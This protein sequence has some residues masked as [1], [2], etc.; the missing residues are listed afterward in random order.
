M[1]TSNDIRATFLGYFAKNGHT[2]VESSPLV[3]RND[4]TLMFANSGMVQFK[5]V[6][7]GQERRPY[8]TA[9]TAQK[10]VRAGG[11]HNDLDNV[12]YTARHHTFF[13][14][15]GNFSFGDYFKEQ[16]ITHAWTL[17]TRDF[18]LPR[19][20]LLVTVF[21]EDEEAAA[22]WR[23]VAGLPDQRIIRIATS[24][25][26]WR[27]G[28][29]G[30]CGPCSEIFF[31]HGEH[32]PGGPPGSPDEDGDRFI[33]IWNLVFMQFLEEPA[34]TRN[35]LPRPSIDTGMGLERF[36]AIL[37]GKHDN[38]DT[39]TF[40]AIILESA[41]LTGQEPDGPFRASHRVVADHLRAG[42]FLIADG[43]LP[44][45]E[46][47]GYVLRRILRRAMRHAH[48]MGA[49][50]PLLHR[51]FPTLE[52]QMA[53]AYP[54]LSRAAAL[55]TETLKLEEN[56]FRSL[57]ERGLGLL[58]GEKEKLAEGEALPGEVA[59]RL[60][61]TYGFPLDLTQD[62][63]RAEGR[64]V[65]VAGFEAAMAAQKQRARAAWAGTGEAAT[66]TLW[67]DLKE[68]LGATEFLGY[69]TERAEGTI[70]ALVAGKDAIGSAAQGREVAVVLNQTPFYGESGGQQGDAGV[71][72]A[73]DAVIRVRDTQKKLG[74][75]F[76]HLGT[77][78]RGDVEVGMAVVAEVDHA[79]R[80]AIRAHHSATHLLHEALRRRLGTHVAQ[81]GSLV[82]PDRLR[83]DVSQPTPIPAADLAVVEAEVNARIRENA[84]VTTRLMTPDAAVAEGAMALFGEKYGEEVRVVAMGRDEAAAERG[85]HYS[86]ELCGGTHVRRTGDIGLF[87][88][89]GEG[90]VSA[91]VRRVEA[92]TGAAA[93]AVV[94]EEA[95]LLREAAAALKA[96]PAD[97][98]A[99]VQAL[100]EDRRRLERELAETR[101]KLA[102]GG[103][104]AELEVVGGLRVALREL[105]EVPARDLKGLAEA[106][107]KSGADV[108]VLVSTEGG[109]A[110]IVAGVGEAGKGRADA[111]ALV[112]AAAA[113]V[114]GK[115]GGGRPDM[116]QAGGPEADKAAEA[117]AAAKAALAG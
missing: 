14:M 77:V 62:A 109:K 56:R 4:P 37:Q 1:S 20:K 104:G 103:A 65:D 6:F 112:R 110:S 64:A 93:L 21:N 45:N 39:D 12:G 71:I 7:T 98:P 54:E 24:D 76:I 50:D 19:E 91:G 28:D 66:E 9:T 111:V 11:K 44:S 113:A 58:E 70:T 88:I 36:A 49:R 73:G 102:T 99:R 86:I 61:D 53:A 92:V 17:L 41:S 78:E 79:R 8:S 107:L 34:G 95:R 30:P 94:E 47:R 13:E 15:L 16:A 55:I 83:F 35:P 67:F 97:I 27:M 18:A 81:K 68:K 117:L 38:Y 114:G 43:V 26:F 80:S 116:A 25:N 63:L 59:F 51:L 75:L 5:N 106:I 72:R 40:R 52:R 87:R 42:S 69:A 108:A 60:Y 29:T 100:L 115:G 3:P 101:R 84:A 48:M 32:I 10:C 85:G 31:D 105:G 89:T 96:S 74:D 57:L 23:K 2:V 46:G 33:E 90:A 22:L 82:A